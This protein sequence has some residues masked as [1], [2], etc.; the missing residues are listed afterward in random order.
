[1]QVRP[2]KCFWH[3]RDRDDKEK[4]TVLTS[5]TTHPLRLIRW[6]RERGIGAGQYLRAWE[7]LA[8]RGTLVDVGPREKQEHYCR[9]GR[10]HYTMTLQHHG[11]GNAVGIPSTELA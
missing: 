1:M 3:V 8:P 10:W 5:F 11:F 2:A 7:G 9:R 6:G 4:L